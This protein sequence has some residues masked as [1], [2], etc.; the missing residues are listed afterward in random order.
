MYIDLVSILFAKLMP[1]IIFSNIKE[2]HSLHNCNLYKKTENGY[3]F[4]DRAH[5]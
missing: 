2:L 3:T 1:I 4:L 5:R